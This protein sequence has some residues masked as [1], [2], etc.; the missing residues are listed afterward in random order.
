[1]NGFKIK[2]GHVIKV[3]TGKTTTKIFYVFLLDRYGIADL[4]RIV[5]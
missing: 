2:E 3:Y 1:M 4:D 5:I